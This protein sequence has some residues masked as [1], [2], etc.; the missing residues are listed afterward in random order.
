MAFYHPTEIPPP[1]QPTTAAKTLPTQSQTWSEKIGACVP[2]A[3]AMSA[4][5]CQKEAALFK[6]IRS[7]NQK[8]SATEAQFCISIHEAVT[9]ER[10]K[11]IPNTSLALPSP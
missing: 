4:R 8:V 11:P 6:I 3:T 1:A 5:K 10:C 9:N 2:K 7:A